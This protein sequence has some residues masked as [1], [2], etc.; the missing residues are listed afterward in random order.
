MRQKKRETEQD[1][2]ESE[3]SEE[4]DERIEPRV[5]EDRRT[6]VLEERKEVSPETMVSVIE[7]ESMEN[8]HESTVE[9]NTDEKNDTDY[10]V[11]S[12][13]ME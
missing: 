12:M 1:V 7:R 4:T 8:V 3:Q 10:S 11:L 5:N 13:G 9:K 2:D 6:V